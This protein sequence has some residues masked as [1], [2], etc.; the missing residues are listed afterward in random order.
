MW[1][2]L[3]VKVVK[4]KIGF[5]IDFVFEETISG[6]KEFRGLI[7][8]VLSIDILKNFARP[9]V[10]ALQFV[11]DTA[12]TEIPKI[13]LN[14]PLDLTVTPPIP[15]TPDEIAKAKFFSDLSNYK[16]RSSILNDLGEPLDQTTIDF[17]DAAKTA[18]KLNYL[19]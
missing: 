7:T 6:R 18:F 10:N 13:P 12:G 11:D 5:N 1:Q 9:I 14:T 4:D 17:L 8:Q 16:R 19:D 3:P 15:P 2:A